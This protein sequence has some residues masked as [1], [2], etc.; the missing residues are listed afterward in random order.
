MKVDR[1][2]VV[3]MLIPVFLPFNLIKGGINAGITLIL[4][5]PIVTALRS[6]KLVE[7]SKGEG[8]KGHF[9]VPFFLVSLAV[10]I[11]FVLAFMAMLGVF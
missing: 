3:G 6:A 2:V 8:G 10:L 1:S 7:P 9:S 4:Y 11:S 5:K